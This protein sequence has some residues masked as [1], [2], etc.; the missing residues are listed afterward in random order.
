MLKQPRR[1]WD[2]NRFD[3]Y[4][5]DTLTCFSAQV[6]YG[7]ALG[8]CLRQFYSRQNML[9]KTSDLD[10]QEILMLSS[11]LANTAPSTKA[12]QGLGWRGDLCH[13]LKAPK[14]L[15]HDGKGKATHHIYNHRQFCSCWLLRK[16]VQQNV[17][18]REGEIYDTY[19]FYMF[20]YTCSI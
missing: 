12:R 6:V 2:L 7:A 20:L 16:C 11:C 8:R 5:Q 9:R 19:S 1:S 13:D 15:T 18:M 17:H 3:L 10:A 14:R 4:A